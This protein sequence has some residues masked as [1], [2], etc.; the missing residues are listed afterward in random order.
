MRV[1]L[2][3]GCQLFQTFVQ[4]SQ[5][6]RFSVIVCLLMVLKVVV[7]VGFFVLLFEIGSHYVV[8]TGFEFIIFLSQP[9]EQC[10]YRHEPSHPT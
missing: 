1:Y 5:E 7:V 6:S 10:Y 3:P 8:Q 2:I 9:P 4:F